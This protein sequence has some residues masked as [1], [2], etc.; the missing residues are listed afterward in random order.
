MARYS[1]S[2]TINGSPVWGD[3]LEAVSPSDARQMAE[4]LFWAG[5]D[6]LE[7]EIPG[8]D[9]LNAEASRRMVALMRDTI[10][11]AK[12]SGIGVTARL[13]RAAA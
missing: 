2:I 11:S 4:R 7:R 8:M 3:T 1:V 12:R 5:P 9:D 6:D 10:A 13:S